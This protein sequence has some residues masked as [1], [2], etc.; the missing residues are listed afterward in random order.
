MIDLDFIVLLRPAWLLL[1]PVV[2]ALAVLASLRAD[3]F[4]R[5]R[6]EIDTDLLPT[7]IALGHVDLGARDFRP[8]FMAAATTAM[9]IGLAGPALRNPGAPVFRNLDAIVILMDLSPSVVEGGGLGDAQAAVAR[10]MDRNGTRPV[11]LIVYTA[12]SFL[13]SVPT[14]EPQTLK[15][16]I[17]VI[18]TQTMPVAGSR[19][20]RALELAQQTLIDAKADNA[21][22][23]VVSDG[24]GFGPEA[25]YQI[26]VLQE[27]EIR[28]SGVFVS[29]NDPPFGVPPAS[30]EK[31][32]TAMG[33]GGGIVVDARN[34][35]ALEALLSARRGLSAEEKARRTILFRDYGIWVFGLGMLILLPIY[36]RRR[37]T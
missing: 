18:D 27:N 8:W 21:D 30:L 15:S 11:A 25:L 28:V 23:I 4:G 26:E 13:V 35:A 19:P 29:H 1:V 32:E 3:G 24:G 12:E 20:D 10:L 37:E 2:V 16:A 33:A 36:Q 34:T 5:W 22:V 14:E 9:A 17:A 6:K 7:L 31:L